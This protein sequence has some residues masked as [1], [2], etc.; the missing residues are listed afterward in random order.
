MDGKFAQ[1]MDEY[2]PRM[3]AAGIDHKIS[4]LVESWGVF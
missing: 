2:I 3:V 1:A 4:Q